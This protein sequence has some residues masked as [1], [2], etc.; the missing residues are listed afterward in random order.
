MPLTTTSL[1]NVLADERHL[2]FGY[3]TSDVL[4]PSRRERL[5]R[6]VV[7]VANDLGLDEET[8]F[9]WTNSKYGRWLVDLVY[10]NDAP[11]TQATVPLAVEEALDG[12]E[13]LS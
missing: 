7:A 1:Q 5:D 10:G 8:L 3:A 4:P 2:G 11:P 13:V 6:A 12:V 9:H